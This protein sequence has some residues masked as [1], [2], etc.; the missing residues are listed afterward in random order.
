MV[1]RRGLYEILLAF[2]TVIVLVT[3]VL[4]FLSL[5]TQSTMLYALL[6]KNA[7]LPKEASLLKEELLACH[8][9]D[10]LEEEKFDAPC[11]ADGLLRG[12]RVV[13]LSLNSCEE[14]VWDRSR[15]QYSSTIPFIVAVAQQGGGRRCLARL[16]VLS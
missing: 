8:H 6:R 12:Y 7:A 11:R 4:I 15:G 2:F 5:E 14:R 10:Y 13:Q 9:L 1:G 16:E 3:S